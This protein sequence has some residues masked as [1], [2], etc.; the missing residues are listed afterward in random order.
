[1]SVALDR[2][3]ALLRSE[4]GMV[5]GESQLPALE[6]ALRRVDP[7]L[8]AATF[9][10]KAGADGHG[11]LDRLIDEVTINETFFFRQRRELDAIDWP[12]L[13]EAARAHGRDAIR[14]WVA[15]CSSG[16]EAYTLAMLASRA[17]AAAQPPLSIVATDISSAILEQARRARY[18][19]RALRLVEADLRRQYFVEDAAGVEVAQG[20]RD[21][22]EFRRHNLVTDPPPGAAA[23]DLIACRNVLI[24]FDGDTVEQVIASLERG[25]APR[26]MLLLGAADRLC[27]SARRLAG[28][29]RTRPLPASAPAPAPARMLRRPLGRDRVEPA[30]PPDRG[31][32]T[33][34]AAANR[35]SL[36][37]TLA[38][39]ERL[40]H[41]DPLDANAYFVR[42]L[43]ELGVDDPDS[44]AASLRRALYVD[45][46][47]GLAAFQLG[48][49]HERRGDGAAAARAYEQALHTLEPGDGRHDAILDQVDLG[50]VA[51][52]CA[53]RLKALRGA[54]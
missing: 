24:Y 50:D 33:A 1:V 31:I 38:L 8:D 13:L 16:E 42:G 49:A 39:T 9:M 22:V 23:F 28:G 26:G 44:A 25:L 53:M 6:A 47:F 54:A 20:I 45:P 21:L 51:S 52:A 40:L 12:R 2:V 35:G 15:A 48:R 19:K 43:A 41:E 29:D 7:Q 46:A 4:S 3:A 10:R 5:L 14:V 34:F 32:D 17:L 18:G 27:G 11:L 30:A 36:E 37:E